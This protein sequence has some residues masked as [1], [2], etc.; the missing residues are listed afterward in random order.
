MDELLYEI[1]SELKAMNITM[2]FMKE[3]LAEH[4]E[5]VIQ[6]RNHINLLDKK[7]NRT[8]FILA[9]LTGLGL[10]NSTPALLKLLTLQ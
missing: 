10:I 7:Y 4:K 2:E 1:K 5:G 6:N 9:F 8:L 3:D